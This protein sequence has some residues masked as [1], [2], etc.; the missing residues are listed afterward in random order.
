MARTVG[1]GLQDFGD[2]I[3][4]NCFYIDKSSFIKEWWESEDSVTLIT[5]PR[6]F[7]KT[8]N[9][10]MVEQFFSVNYA[11]HGEVFQG[12]SIW[13]EEKYRQLQGTYPVISL[14][15]ANVKERN[16]QAAK[17]RICQLI[18][19]LY[20]R[21]SFLRE[22]DW[23]ARAD[24]EF[25][26]SVRADMPEVVASFAIHK[27]CDFLY[28][29]YGKKVIILLD[30][31]DTP[32]QEAYVDGYW[33]ELVGFTRSMFN[34]AFK[35]NPW[36]ERAIMTGITRISKESIFSDLNNLE[37]VTT[38]SNKYATAFGFTEEEVFTALVECGFSAEKEKVKWWYDGFI[39]GDHK[40]IY[41]PWS[42]LNF[43]DKGK[44]STYWANTSSNSLVGKLL[45]E[46]NR[47]IKEQFE[48][49][50]Q[51]ERIRTPIDE[52]I[53]Y[54][55]LDHNESAIWSLLLASGYVKVLSYDREEL[56]ESGEEV[57]YELTLTNYEVERM[58][59]NMVRGWFKCVQVDYN[60]FIKA[61]L[62]D[63]IDAM[64]EYMNRVAFS[65]FSYFD[66]GREPSREEPERF[67]HG[68]VLGLMVDLQ[69]RYIIT[70]NQESGF[71]RYDVVLEPRN[72][73][74]DD[75]IILEFKVRNKR[76]E[77]NLEE[78][79]EAALRQIEE[80]QYA[81]KLMD[82]GISKRQI[83][84]YGFAFEGKTVLIG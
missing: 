22:C 41:N 30:E 43:L 50:L 4:K 45:R 40:D 42:I 46:G 3:R 23:M 60:D 35:T 75:A 26:D 2:L 39:F 71:G 7:G 59:N 69:N 61:M 27:L 36:L 31:Y 49:L 34:S 56:L 55:Q 64:N 84:C 29:Y 10:S 57:Q 63:D 8:L 53:V 67:Y 81:A 1:I 12:L 19:D 79:V 32:M 13:T 78:T 24:K 48:M 16:Y 77:D 83:R 38:T 47:R 9:M 70:S 58:F 72:Q 44:F 37:V 80:K 51:G 5:R 20:V 52:Q 14:S 25:F 62:E 11:D 66:T 15:F 21:N 33:E 28:R 73:A 68:F 18:T 6:R 17:D 82:H 76:K 74:V 54:N 65:T